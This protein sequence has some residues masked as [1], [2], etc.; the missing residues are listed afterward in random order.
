VAWPVLKEVISSLWRRLSAYRVEYAGRT[1]GARR[2]TV[3]WEQDRRSEPAGLGG[4]GD[5][6][7]HRGRERGAE[8]VLAREDRRRR[9]RASLSLSGMADGSSLERDALYPARRSATRSTYS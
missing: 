3:A 8:E 5:N 9:R 7:P 2:A 1:S 6:G 4:R